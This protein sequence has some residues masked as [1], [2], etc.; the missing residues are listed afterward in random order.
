MPFSGNWT[1]QELY[2]EFHHEKELNGFIDW[3]RAGRF[4]GMGKE[5]M[6]SR[7][8]RWADRM[9]KPD[10]SA[11]VNPV[12][13]QPAFE[14]TGNTGEI[15]M[16]SA[17]VI[18]MSAEQLMDYAGV[19]RTIWRQADKQELR[20]WGQNSKA[21]G[22]RTLFYV[23][24]PLVRIKPIPTEWE[25]LRPVQFART[26][27]PEGEI[28]YH[29]PESRTVVLPDLHIGFRKNVLTGEYAPY[30]DRHAIALALSY[31]QRVQPR[32]VVLGGDVTD[33]PEQS[34][35]FS[36]EPEHRFT[37]QATIIELGYII[38]RIR[39]IVPSARIVVLQGNHD[40]RI[41]DQF[42]KVQQWA[43]GIHAVQALGDYPVM[44]LPYLLDFK[45]QN[46]E[47]V[48]GYPG[49]RVRIGER[50]FV[51]HG[52]KTRSEPGATAKA[53]AT[54]GLESI[55][56]CHI[57]KREQ[58]VDVRWFDGMRHE[59]QAASPGTLSM[60]DETVPGATDRRRWTQ[61]IAD[62][63]SVGDHHQIDLVAIRNGKMITRG[64][65][66][67]DT[68]H[69]DCSSNTFAAEFEAILTTGLR[70]VTKFR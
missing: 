63:T 45:G 42:V 38:A 15:T 34:G 65:E 62:V 17:D 21:H 30:H 36:P 20:S 67:Q 23:R 8:R 28:L 26:P 54:S 39:A 61:G 49:A 51:E 57:H 68:L 55:I 52:A 6:R 10:L 64:W 13:E 33:A 48:G 29:N 25:P 53:I 58:L 22:Y 3:V 69:F 47:W 46:I 44:S 50:L 12:P 14:E 66:L 37:F 18:I 70:S 43:Y 41:E 40:K 35:R 27:M 56:F 11:G 24:A 19:D 4:T 59:V 60:L 32:T 7:Y 5:K 2:D 31:I 9:S 16:T 1:G